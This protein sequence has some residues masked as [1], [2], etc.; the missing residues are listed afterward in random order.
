[1]GHMPTWNRMVVSGHASY[2]S[3]TMSPTIL[4][5]KASLWLTT[6]KHYTKKG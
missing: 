3:N 6:G 2:M 1:M 4:P 5:K